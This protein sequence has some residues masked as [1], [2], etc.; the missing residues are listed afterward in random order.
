[1][2]KLSA[3]RAKVQAIFKRWPFTV[4]YIKSEAE[5]VCSVIVVYKGNMENDS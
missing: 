5:V 4:V 1:M 2:Q 3:E